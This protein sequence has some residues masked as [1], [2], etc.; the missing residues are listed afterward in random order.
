MKLCH[1]IT[2]KCSQEI[3]HFLDFEVKTNLRYPQRH[4]LF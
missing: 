3:N 2:S 4:L 1:N